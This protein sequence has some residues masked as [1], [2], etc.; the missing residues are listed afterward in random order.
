MNPRPARDAILTHPR[1]FVPLDSYAVRLLDS[2]PQGVVVLGPDGVI[3]YANEFAHGILGA[4]LVGANIEDVLLPLEVLLAA[5]GK[6]RHEINTFMPSARK[7]RD[8][9]YRIR[10]FTEELEDRNEPLRYL[11]VFSDVTEGKIL[12]EERDRLLQLAAVGNV[13]PAI[14]H[15]IKNP[16][17][18]IRSTVELLVEENS[19]LPFSRELYA[20]LNEI[21]R[22][23]ITMDGVGRLQ[24]DLRSSR[25]HPVDQACIDALEVLHSQAG[26]R[27]I[28]LSHHVPALPLLPLDPSGFRALVY[29]LLTNAIQACRRGDSITMSVGMEGS[30]LSLGIEDTGRGMTPEVLARC[31]ELF[32]TTKSNGTGIG[33]ALCKTLVES[34]GGTLHVD[35]TPG[36]GTR[37]DIRVPLN[38]NPTPTPGGTHVAI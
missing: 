3:A 8:I 25:F 30:V 28:T 4:V 7:Q 14:L 15:E 27:G 18:S 29:N 35:S 22:I 11:L 23:T 36:E 34:T 26:E 19:N 6:E 1:A 5:L 31:Q 9:E 17:A 33:L 16:L 12:R 2:L 38:L 32:F 37:I 20:V 24:Q 13:L 10:T 21:R